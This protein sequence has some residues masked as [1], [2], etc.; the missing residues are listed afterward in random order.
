MKKRVLKYTIP[1]VLTTTNAYASGLT[2]AASAVFSPGKPG[3]VVISLMMVAVVSWLAEFLASTVGKG[4]IA[5]MIRV[6]G[7]FA[8]IILVGNALWSVLKIIS[9]LAG[10]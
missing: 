5:S 10:L 3:F 4:Q 7:T 2:A 8:A 1:L 9:N 6:G